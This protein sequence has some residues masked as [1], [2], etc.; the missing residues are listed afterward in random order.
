VIAQPIDLR[1]DGGMLLPSL[2]LV[3]LL[4]LSILG[5]VAQAAFA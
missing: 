3:I 4:I 2:L 1:R 5:V